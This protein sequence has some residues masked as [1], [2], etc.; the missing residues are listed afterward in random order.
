MVEGEGD[1]HEGDG[2]VHT[3]VGTEMVEGEGDAHEG[4]SEVHTKLGTNMVEGEGDAHEG[5]S[6][7]HTELGTKMVEGEGDAHEG[8]SE[9]AHEGD[10]EDAEVHH[11][12]DG[13]VHHVEEVEV[14]DFELEDLGEDDDVEDS[15][16]EDVHEAETEDEDVD[17]EEVDVSEESLIDVSV[18]CDIGTSKGNVRQEPSSVVL[19]S[20]RSDNVCIDDVRGLSD[21]EWVLEELISGSDSEDNDGSTKIRFPTF[22]MPKTLEAYKW[23]VGTYFA[24]KNEFTD[25]IR[26]YAL[27]NGRSL[28]FRKGFL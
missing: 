18:Q 8:D 28:K 13:E 4:D 20:S 9:G 1:A 3:E 6:E 16:D 25:A 2:E 17:Y 15:E 7:V 21:N 12:E 22:S 10:G 14:H 5:D 24:E 19:E 23:E 26:T 11:V 27:S